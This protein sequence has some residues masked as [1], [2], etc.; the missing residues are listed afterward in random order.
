MIDWT[1][2]QRGVIGSALRDGDCVPEILAEMRPEDF[3]GELRRY[4]EA[5]SALSAEGTPVDRVTVAAFLGPAYVELTEELD[6]LTPTA[7]NVSAYIAICKEQSRLALLRRCGWEMQS[8]PTLELAREALDHAAE[9]S[10][11]SG[12]N[13]SRTAGECAAEWYDALVRGE[14]PEYLK[15]GIAPLDDTLRTVGGDYVVV[16]GYTS[17]GK[18]A[19]GLQIAWA[20]S[21]E[22][23]VGYFAFEGSRDQWTGRLISYLAQVPLQRVRDRELNPEEARRCAL[24]CAALEKRKLWF[25]SAAGF[26]VEDIRA[27]TLRQRYD[28]IFVD[29]LQKV[30]GAAEEGKL[31]R[32]QEVSAVSGGLQTMGLRYG[33][34]VYAMSQLSRAERSGGEYVP[35]PS[36][37]DLRESG[38]IEQDADAVLFVHAPFRRTRPGMRVLDVAKVRNG[39]LHCFFANFRGEVQRFETPTPEEAEEYARA[40]EGAGQ[41]YFGRGPQVSPGAG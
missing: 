9:A 19:M 29:Y 23:R 11:D 10:L 39:T 3:E 30:R 7:A 41:G 12:K 38:Q 24:A 34:T 20:L 8:A 27:R 28:V 40:M 13:R 15:T 21:R 6:R 33:V 4:Y 2:A 16:A 35:L 37:R 26:C 31:S 14:K 36:L 25:E 22:K 5:F 17:H 1:G 32:Y 18:S